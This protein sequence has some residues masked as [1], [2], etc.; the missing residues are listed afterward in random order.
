MT[1]NSDG[2]EFK[3]IGPIIEI[4]SQIR[5]IAKNMEKVFKPIAQ[6]RKL[7]VLQV[8]IIVG[9][10]SVNSKEL[11]IGDLGE[12]AGISPGNISNIV[13]NLES[14]GYLVRVPSEEDERVVKI[15]L[16][17]EAINLCK[18]VEEHLLYIDNKLD[19]NLSIEELR[20]IISKLGEFAEVV[21]SA[22]YLTKIKL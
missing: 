1:I 7:T 2:F 14:R 10:K 11:S 5:H 19:N 21:N 8:L 18:E 16:T 22:T 13:S 9:I 20:E 15:S 12:L 17:E 4:Y 3:A 6:K